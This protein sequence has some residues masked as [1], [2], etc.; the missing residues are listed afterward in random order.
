MI[1]I[2]RQNLLLVEKQE[3]TAPGLRRIVAIDSRRGKLE[4][5][6]EVDTD[7]GNRTLEIY[8]IGTG[9][10]VPAVVTDGWER[11]YLGHVIDGSFVFHLYS[12]EPERR[13]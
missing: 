13:P 11:T 10:E 2:W 3:I 6:F 5:W 12:V 7:A 1:S 9:H 4:A 8:I